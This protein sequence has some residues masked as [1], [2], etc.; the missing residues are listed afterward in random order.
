MANYR[1]GRGF[2]NSLI[3]KLPIELHLPG[4]YQYCGPGTHLHTRLR[5]GDPGINPLDRACKEH[6]IAYDNFSD[7]TNRHRADKILEERA[8]GRVKSSDASLSERL[9]ARFV[10]SAM[11]GKRKL[12]M[13]I[14]KCKLGKGAKKR[15]LGMGIKSSKIKRGCMCTFKGGVL[16]RIRK[17]LKNEKNLNV[18]QL[19]NKGLAAAKHIVK[20]IGGKNKIKLPRLIPI[21]KR[22]GLLPF[23]VPLFAGLSAI[24]GIAGGVSNI[25]SAVNKAAAAKKDFEESRRHNRVMEA[26]A[27]GSSSSSS[28]RALFLKPYK[29]G[30]A[31]YLQPSK[32]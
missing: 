8:W 15:K 2:L 28:G 13:G 7:L 3:N 19:V 20:S 12:G 26:M 6:D 24:G 30:L 23:L 11:K 22:G 32:N 10:T 29:K 25:V 27:L 4:G 5:R 21:P 14:K 18:V 17:L 1:Q 16:S 31:L 9:A